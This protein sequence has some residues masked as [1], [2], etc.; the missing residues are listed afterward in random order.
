M[1][2]V[3]DDLRAQRD[4]ALRELARLERQGTE[5]HDLMLTGADAPERLGAA[6][7]VWQRDCASAIHQLAGGSKSHW[8]SRAFSDALLVRADDGRTLAEADPKAIV[9]RVVDVLA[10]ARR[11]LSDMGDVVVAS[12]AAPPVPRFEFVHNATL[13]PILERALDES[14]RAF[15]EHDFSRSLITSC[16]ILESIL[17]DALEYGAIMTGPA[18]A[19]SFDARIAAAEKSGLIRGGCSRLPAIARAYRDGET[20]VVTAREA[21]VARQVLH[22]VMRDLNP[23]R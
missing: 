2:P 4:Y 14:A 13:R 1:E 17:T 9:L 12:S 11:S 19:W 8:L 3:A 22:V 21:K 6:T 16:S 18:D 5:L 10:R 15:D 7:S 20:P 23:G